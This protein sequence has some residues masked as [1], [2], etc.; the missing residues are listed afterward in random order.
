MKSYHNKLI[1]R[2]YCLLSLLSYVTKSK[3]HEWQN[4][5]VKFVERLPG[6][7]NGM[8]TQRP[9]WGKMSRIE[10]EYMRDIYIN[11]HGWLA[12][13]GG[14]NSKV[15]AAT[16][17]IKTYP[18]PD[19]VR[20]WSAVNDIYAISNTEIDRKVTHLHTLYQ[21]PT[22]SSRTYYTRFQGKYTELLDLGKELH[23]EEIGLMI[24]KGLTPT[25]KRL[26]HPF[27]ANHNLNCTLSNMSKLCK[28]A[29]EMDEDPNPNTSLVIPPAVTFQANLATN[30]DAQTDIRSIYG[31]VNNRYDRENR[32]SNGNYSRFNN[33]RQ[34]NN[35]GRHNITT[36]PITSKATTQTTMEENIRDTRDKVMR[37]R[38]TSPIA[39]MIT[40]IN[41]HQTTEPRIGG[42]YTY[43]QTGETTSERVRSSHPITLLSHSQQIT[44]EDYPMK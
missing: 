12:K 42:C 19:I 31:T 1:R 29:D 2:L 41:N 10:Q 9:D 17:G 32:N 18:Y 23:D 44:L 22:E 43:I 21:F 28:Y 37:E 16:K 40:P 27:M 15:T 6:Y 13:A 24:F 8:L 33:R 26:L 30:T 34:Q 35:R 25:N 7:V 20:W 14:E 11:I 38:L 5:L 36:G 3:F 39:A 4:N